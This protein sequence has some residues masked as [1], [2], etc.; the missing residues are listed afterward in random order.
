MIG[1]LAERGSYS[2]D[3]LVGWSPTSFGHVQVP[4]FEPRVPYDLPVMSSGG[5]VVVGSGFLAAQRPR[6]DPEEM[7]AVLRRSFDEVIFWD[8]ADPFQLDLDASEIRHFS[9]VV[10]IN[11]IYRDPDLYNFEVGSPSPS[12]RW[13]EKTAVRPGPRYDEA[14]VRAI[15]LV[16][17]CF[18][19]SVPAVRNRTR[20]LYQPS[21]E[22]QAKNVIDQ[23]TEAWLRLGRGRRPRMTAHLAGSLTHVQRHDALRRLRA[24]K[25]R[26]WGGIT[27]VPSFIAGFGNAFGLGK[28]DESARSGVE[29]QL[30]TEGLMMAPLARPAFIASMLKCKAVVSITGYGEICFRM[31]EAWASGRVLVCQDLSHVRIDYPLEPGRNVIYCRPDLT[32]LAAI[33]EDIE[34]R[35]ERYRHVGEQGLTDWLNWTKTAPELI[36]GALTFLQT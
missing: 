19:S 33:L 29:A 26:V 34:C 13:V 9:R 32:D 10:K 23:A 2:L 24:A 27:T 20:R 28:L 22:R 17:P 21:W 31:A 12:G 8:H 18:L 1:L 3:A 4:G 14:L 6:L 25:L 11:G 5:C 16:P 36:D 35:W 15:R 7:V 30:R